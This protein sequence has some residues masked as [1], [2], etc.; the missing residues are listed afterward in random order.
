MSDTIQSTP[1]VHTLTPAPDVDTSHHGP[2]VS[3]YFRK[4]TAYE[5]GLP[6][7]FKNPWPSYRAPSLKDAYTA[8]NLGA[9]IAHPLPYKLGMSR[10]Q[11]NLPHNQGKD[12]YK[13]EDGSDAPR[14][15]NE[16]WLPQNTYVRPI[17]AE[18][19]E[20]DEEQ[21]WRDPPVKVVQPTFAS[22]Q[23]DKSKVTW[24]GHAGVLVQV[25]WQRGE[26]DGMFGVLYDPIFSYR[27]VYEGEELMQV[28]AESICRARASSGPAV[29]CFSAAGYPR[30]LHLA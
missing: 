27:Y 20:D 1:I 5:N 2:F 21:D 9:A 18:Q 4:N 6:R 8:Y 19:F 30:R 12:V 22:E 11:L 29:S 14:L 28:L 7:F 24:L 25:P 17:F 15:K 16:S 3:H 13:T 26:R 10:S 23:T